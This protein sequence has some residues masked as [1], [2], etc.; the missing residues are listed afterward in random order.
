MKETLSWDALHALVSLHKEVN[1]HRQLLASLKHVLKFLFIR[2]SHAW[3]DTVH[4][5][6]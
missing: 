4:D 1:P 2:P 5:M 6:V 3:V